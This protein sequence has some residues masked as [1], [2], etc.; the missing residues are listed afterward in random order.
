MQKKII[1]KAACFM[2]GDDRSINI[3]LDQDYKPTPKDDSIIQVPMMVSSLINPSTKFWCVNRLEELFDVESIEAIKRIQILIRPRQDSLMWIKDHNVLNWQ[4]IWNL[5]IQER[6]KMLLW[7]IRDNVLPTK[8]ILHH[9]M[10]LKML[11][12]FFV[13][14]AQKQRRIC[15][16]TAK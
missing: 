10:V 11:I 14:R 8:E 6:L 7:R 1:V 4:N 2:V 16:S 13:R 15:S 5:K 12:V 3:W 9:R